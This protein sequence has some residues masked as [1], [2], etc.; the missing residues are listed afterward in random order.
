MGRIIAEYCAYQKG[1]HLILSDLDRDAVDAVA[2]DIQ[3][4]SPDT[5]IEVIGI[6]LIAENACNQLFEQACAIGQVYVFINCIG[7]DYNGYTDSQNWQ[8]NVAIN[9]INFMI[10]CQLSVLFMEYF[11]A[12]GEGGM[13]HFNSLAAY[14][15]FPYKT[16]YA[17][18]K[19]ALN[20]FLTGL[21]YEIRD[22]SIQISQIYPGSID[23]PLTWNA[24]VYSQLTKQDRRLI[25]DP[26]NVARWAIEDFIRRRKNIYTRQFSSYAT[27]VIAPLFPNLANN[28]A[29]RAYA[30]LLGFLNSV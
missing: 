19:S 9:A 22:T 24:P 15:S 6:D 17:A 4:K 7:L 16:M 13:L 12:H 26:R 21:R 28:L 5:K 14:F 3:S 1:A 25:C 18:T 2:R 29:G 30:R 8:K 23:T 10:P 20:S 11:R 27:R